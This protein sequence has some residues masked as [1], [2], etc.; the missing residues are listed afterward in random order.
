MIL[1]INTSQA[2]L[3]QVALIKKN[4]IIGQII[5]R[6]GYRH[7]ELLLPMIDAV[8]KKSKIRLDNLKF[9]GVVNSPGA[10]SALRLGIITA[11]ILSW[12]LK[13]PVIEVSAKETADEDKLIK[14]LRDKT[15]KFRSAA[16]NRLKFAVPKYG[17]KPNITKP[18]K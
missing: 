18:N 7:V 12:G 13:A 6:A 15:K 14:I 11:N 5:N 1:F 9:I 17:K 2:D 8:L 3:I 10:F 4:K 16:D